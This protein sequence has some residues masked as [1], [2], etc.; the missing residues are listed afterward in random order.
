MPKGDGE[1]GH[2]PVKDFADADL[3]RAARTACGREAGGGAQQ[4]NEEG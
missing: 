1:H 4:E 3:F 2:R